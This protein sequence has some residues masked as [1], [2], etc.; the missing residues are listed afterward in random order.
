VPG[1]KREKGGAQDER[2]CQEP[3]AGQ[4]KT[5]GPPNNSCTLARFAP[6]KIK[7]D[8]SRKGEGRINIGYSGSIEHNHSQSRRKKNRY[9]REKQDI[10]ANKQERRGSN[11][12]TEGG[13]RH[14][15]TR[16]F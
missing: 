8:E 13:G 10:I 15:G 9:K 12:T 1:K 7:M 16:S 2:G 3:K 11:H 6:N 4:C 5:N 14:R